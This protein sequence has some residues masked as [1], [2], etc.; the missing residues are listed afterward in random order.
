VSHLTHHHIFR[1]FFLPHTPVTLKKKTLSPN[2][3]H[4]FNHLVQMCGG[5][6]EIKEFILVTLLLLEIHTPEKLH[7]PLFCFVFC[8]V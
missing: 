1:P 2:K 6:E 4:K 8:F 3:P 5:C 7:T